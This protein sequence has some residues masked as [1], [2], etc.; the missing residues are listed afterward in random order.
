MF[1]RLFELIYIFS[2]PQYGG[3]KKIVNNR[4]TN[5]DH[6]IIK[7]SKVIFINTLSSEKYFNNSFKNDYFRTF[8]R[9]MNEI[10][11]VDAVRINFIQ[12]SHKNLLNFLS[13]NSIACLYNWFTFYFNS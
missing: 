9:N 3:K 10:I 8:R 6:T 2:L 5:F 12:I 7:T 11:E 4:A 13:Q 1:I